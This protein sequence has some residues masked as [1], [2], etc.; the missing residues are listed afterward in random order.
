MVN[1]AKVKEREVR[2]GEMW[3]EVS[4]GAVFNPAVAVF[5]SEKLWIGKHSVYAKNGEALGPRESERYQGAVRI[6]GV[7]LGEGRVKFPLHP[8]KL[9]KA[10]TQPSLSSSCHRPGPYT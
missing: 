10:A 4:Q 1:E 8:W 6:G 5:V 9:A 7:R 3:K 2:A